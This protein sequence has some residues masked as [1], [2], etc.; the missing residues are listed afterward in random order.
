MNKI[1]KV[2]ALLLAAV[3]VMSLAGCAKNET[4][5]E[6]PEVSTT[7][8]EESKEESSEEVKEETKEESSEEVV[9]EESSEEADSME[10]PSL[11]VDADVNIA[12][13]SG[14]TGVGASVLMEQAENGETVNNY[15]FTVAAANDEITAGLT[16]GSLDI[17]AIATNLAA[18]Y[19]QKSEGAIQIIALNTLGVLHIL[20]RGESIQSMADLKGKTIMSPGQGANPEYVL[21]YLL[22]EAGLTYSTDGSEADVQIEFTDAPTI[23][24]A[25]ADGSCDV[26]MLPVPAATAVLVQN[27]DVRAALDMTEE[28][29][30][31]Q[32]GGQLTMGCVVVRTAFAQ[33]NPEAVAAFLTEYA[34]SIEAVNTDPAHAGELCETYGI[35]AKAAIATKS[36]PSCN[37]VCIVGDEIRTTIEPYYEV[38]FAANP[39]AVGGSLPDDAFYYNN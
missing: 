2:L 1:S 31:S 22:T 10:E 30:N 35:V 21:E 26:C 11:F 27:S 3:M 37:L 19:Y 13:L 32:A 6:E 17:A 33:E 34:A 5:V 15:T 7:T 23:Q 39:A 28:W 9:V 24:A 20:E 12:V 38:L 25:V 29:N 14:P 36:I 4:K 8:V 16:N 18:V